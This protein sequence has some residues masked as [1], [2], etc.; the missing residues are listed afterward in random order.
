MLTE[1]RAVDPF[2][3]EYDEVKCYLIEPNPLLRQYDGRQGFGAQ[4]IFFQKGTR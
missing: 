1:W 3:S 4:L 2:D